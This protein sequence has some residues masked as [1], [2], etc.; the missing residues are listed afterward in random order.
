MN[1]GKNLRLSV[2]ALARAPLRTLLSASAMAIGVA[3]VVM[4]LGVGGGAER[5][6]QAALQG[7][8][9]N[10]LAV[11]SERKDSS[12][13]RGPGGRFETLTL[14]DS[15][16]IVAQ[17]D[18]VERA[19]PIAMN[20]FELRYGGRSVSSTV[21]GTTPEFRVTNNQI[22]A[23]GRFLD[24]LD[25]AGYERVA[26]IGA[27]IAKDL[28]AGEVPL[29]ER[30]LVDNMPF[31]VVGVLQ[32]KGSDITG[33]SEDDRVLVPVSTAQRRLLNV[34][35]V[36]RIFVQAGSQETLPATQEAVRGLLRER[37]GL[38]DPPVADDFTVRDQAKVLEA[39]KT[40][41]RSLSRML[42]GLAILTLGLA[43]LGLLAV[44]LLSVRE[45]QSEIG[46]RLAVGA[47]PCHVLT[48]FLAEAVLIALLGALIGLLIGGTGIIVGERLVGWRLALTWKAV[49][50]PF[51]ISLALSLLFGGYPALRAA[52]LDPI[53][54]LR[55]D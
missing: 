41:D 11:G 23:A 20:S 42:A 36:D 16:A 2:H 25:L 47:L 19:A 9:R 53:V 33:T 49:A 30:L 55:S 51:T 10:L 28:F 37:H 48:Q 7:M 45:R 5:A 46:L 44:T 8:G 38:E 21:I 43:S 50:Y 24:E 54:A 3:S 26:V 35:Y 6:F 15:R 18:S 52:R 1:F 14:D 13:L 12:A 29:G 39:M 31:V 17:L 27:Q 34:D 40:S 32:A 22:L 4:L